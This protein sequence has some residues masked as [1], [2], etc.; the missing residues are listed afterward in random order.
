MPRSK[1]ITESLEFVGKA[2]KT[3]NT[4][5]NWSLEKVTHYDHFQGK[6]IDTTY[7][8]TLTTVNSGTTTVT[9]PHM[10]TLTTNA[11]DDDNTEFAMGVEWYGKYDA[12]MEARF[13]NDDVTNGSFFIGF[14]DIQ[15][16]GADAIPIEFVAGD[17]ATTAADVAGILFDVDCTT[18]N[19]YFGS[20]KSNADGATIN[21]NVAITASQLY[22]ARIELKDGATGGG[23]DAYFYLNSTGNKIDPVADF[24]AV[25]HDAVTNTTALCPYIGLINRVDAVAVTLDVDYL[26]VWQD[27]R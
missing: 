3:S 25:E 4:K 20:A 22:T 11:K 16:E 7:D 23:C 15:T 27:E 12:T 5:G 17:I 6:A 10:L 9:V 14:T 18:P 21:T 26:K 8:Y 2:N 13:R 1:K 19:L 24:V